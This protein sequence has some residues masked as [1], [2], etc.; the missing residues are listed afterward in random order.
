[1]K[2]NWKIRMFLG[3]VCL[4]LLGCISEESITEEVGEA[5]QAVLNN[6]YTNP[7][8]IDV[9]TLPNGKWLEL[10]WSA[11]CQTNWARSGSSYDTN[12][13]VYIQTTWGD[14]DE[15]TGWGK[16]FYTDAAYCPSPCKAQACE[17]AEGSYPYCTAW[18]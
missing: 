6:C 4:S 2:R 14:Y 17:W 12:H 9:K 10:R 13:K 18:L 1:M 7:T 15:Q 16:G 11:A 3:A 5:E 8:S